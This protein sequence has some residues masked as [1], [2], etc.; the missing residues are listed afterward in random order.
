VTTGSTPAPTAR[1]ALI[2]AGALGLAYGAGL[3]WAGACAVA[4]FRVQNLGHPY[5]NAIPGLRTDT[6]GAVAF[7]VLALSLVTARFQYLERMRIEPPD[8]AVPRPGSGWQSAALAIGETV[9]VL[10]TGLVV[11]LSANAVI[12]PAT[13]AI[14]ATHFA[15]WPTEGTLRVLALAGCVLGVAGSRYYRAARGRRYRSGEIAGRAQDSPSPD[16]SAG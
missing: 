10:S 5:W 8:P 14:R 2:E 6:C 11:Y 12:H 3:C 13:L 4:S 9:A 7:L 16:A 15:P 1:R